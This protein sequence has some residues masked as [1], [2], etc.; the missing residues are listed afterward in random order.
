VCFDLIFEDLVGLMGLVDVAFLLALSAS[1]S[2]LEHI[3]E[4]LDVKS[5]TS[6]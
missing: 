6:D 2:V 4:L 3:G 5:W 1:M